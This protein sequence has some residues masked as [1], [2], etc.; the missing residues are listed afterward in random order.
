MIL[1]VAG[2]IRGV[3]P[4]AVTNGVAEARDAVVVDG[5]LRLTPG[6]TRRGPDL[7]DVLAGRAAAIEA[8]DERGPVAVLPCGRPLTDDRTA[9]S[10]ADALGDVLARVDRRYGDVVIDCPP[11]RR[12]TDAVLR[13]AVACVL[14]ATP[15]CS[16]STI[17]RA[18]ALARSSNARIDR[19]VYPGSG[20]ADRSTSA[21]NERRRDREAP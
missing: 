10:T 5:R 12:A 14:V 2:A 3:E 18:R 9:T 1:A 17:D 20:G 15:D 16:P 19:V 7:H 21:G 8:V 11:P 6:A 4:G 13:A